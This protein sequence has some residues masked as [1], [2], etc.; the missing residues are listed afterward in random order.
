MRK[1]EVHMDLEL[2]FIIIGFSGSAVGED[3]WN[4]KFWENSFFDQT[5]KQYKR[6]YYTCHSFRIIN[7]KK[8]LTNERCFR[9]NLSFSFEYSLFSKFSGTILLQAK[10]F[11]G[12]HIFS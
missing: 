8:S 5:N 7:S 2:F 12:Y 4:R 11:V 3:K 6:K 9:D 1:N 10:L